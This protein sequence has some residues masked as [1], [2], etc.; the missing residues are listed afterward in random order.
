M[1]VE[2]YRPPKRVL[3]RRD[4]PARSLLARHAGGDLV[5]R[6]LMATGPGHP[7]RGL[8]LRGLGAPPDST[9]LVQRRLA[10][11]FLL[12][13]IWPHRTGPEQTFT[14]P[15]TFALKLSEKSC[16]HPKLSCTEHRHRTVR[17]ILAP[18]YR[19]IPRSER[20]SNP[21][22]DSF[23]TEFSEV[24]GSKKLGKVQ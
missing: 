10:A 5:G 3:E 23:I 9:G 19:P 20:H 15:G 7:G 4:I 12:R 1:P 24:R 16:R 18:I 2:A 6:Y 14:A 13:S 21:F 22:S 11:L 8:R 17:P